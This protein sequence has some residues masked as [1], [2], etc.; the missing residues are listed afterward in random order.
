M[1]KDLPLAAEILIERY[2]MDGQ[3]TRSLGDVARAH[4]ITRASVRELESYMVSLLEELAASRK[5]DERAA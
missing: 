2:G 5:R 1:L 4:G 3:G